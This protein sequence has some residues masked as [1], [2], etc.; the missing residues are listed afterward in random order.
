MLKKILLVLV[1]TFF[2]GQANAERTELVLGMGL[3]Y[4][5]SNQSV[6]SWEVSSRPAASSDGLVG[7]VKVGFMPTPVDAMYGFVQISQLNYDT[8]QSNI[9]AAKLTLTG[10]GYSHYLNSDIGS[11]FFSVAVA[12]G[13]YRSNGGNDALDYRGQAFML[14]TGY[15]VLKHLQLSSTIMFARM[16]DHNFYYEDDMQDISTTSMTFNIEFKL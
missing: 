14:E 9:D 16:S 4:G 10:V 7:R 15:E 13:G 1:V 6:S 5:I 12:T 3:G 11:P 2:A 8:Q